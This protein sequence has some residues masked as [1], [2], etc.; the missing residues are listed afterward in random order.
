VKQELNVLFA[1]IDHHR[2]VG[3]VG[4]LDFD[5]AHVAVGARDGGLVH[6]CVCVCV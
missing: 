5:N 2:R 4:Y 6:L 3:V 1:V